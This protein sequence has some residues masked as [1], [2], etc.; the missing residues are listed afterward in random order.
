M[1]A[2]KVIINNSVNMVIA[3]CCRKLFTFSYV[4]FIARYASI[5]NTDAYISPELISVDIKGQMRSL[6][7]ANLVI[8]PVDYNPVSGMIKVTT[9]HHS[10]RNYPL[11]PLLIGIGNE[12]R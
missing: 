3:L 5:Y 10:L 8:R 6:R 2:K 9:N 1:N 11:Q 4:L 12:T 7:M